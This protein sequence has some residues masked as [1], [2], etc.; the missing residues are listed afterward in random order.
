MNEKEQGS[1]VLL[2]DLNSYE[3]AKTNQIKKLTEEITNL[4]KNKKDNF[5]KNTQFINYIQPDTNYLN[6]IGRMQAG[7]NLFKRSPNYH[8]TGVSQI[9]QPNINLYN[10]YNSFCNYDLNG[11]TVDDMSRGNCNN[12]FSPFSLK[13]L[14]TQNLQNDMANHNYNLMTNQNATNVYFNTNNQSNQSFNYDN[15]NS[16]KSNFEICKSPKPANQNFNSNLNSDKKYDDPFKNLVS[17]L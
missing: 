9:N 13:S 10:T 11:A 14:M 1:S 12:A 3:S 5:N 4:Y 17:F 7:N 8:P 6:N 2:I 15:Y 16:I